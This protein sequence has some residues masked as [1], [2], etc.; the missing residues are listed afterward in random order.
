L[1]GKYRNDETGQAAYNPEILFTVVLL[2]YSRGLISSRKIE[3]ASR[4]NGV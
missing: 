3:P 4:E 2:A 1:D